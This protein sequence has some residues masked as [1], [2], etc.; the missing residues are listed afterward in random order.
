MRVSLAGVVKA[1]GAHTVL[2][3]VDLALGLRSRL[4]LV[5]P[6]GAGK[7]TLLRLLAGVEEPDE[8]RVERTPADLTVGYLPQEHD[9]RPGETLLAFLARRTGVAAAEAELE[10]HTSAWDADAYAAALERFL[11]LGGGDLEHRAAAVCAELGLPVSLGQETATLSGGEAA[12]AGLAA[13]LLSRF[14]VLLLDEPTNDLDFD[15]LE[16]LERFLGRFDGGLAVVSHDRAFLDRTIERIAEIDPWTG[17]VREWAGTWSEYEAQRERARRRH[18]DAFERAQERRREIEG[19]LHERRA[20]ARAGGAMADRRGTHALMTKV[21]QAERALERVEAVDKPYEPWELRLSLAARQRTGDSV[22]SL[23]GAVGVRGDFRLGPVDVDLV[24]G[25]RLAVTGRNGSGKS[26]LLALLL[27][28]LPLAAGRRVVGRAT[29]LGALDQRRL[30]Y[31]GAD[32]LLDAFVERS[33]VTSLEARTLLAKFNLTADHVARACGTLSPGER[34]RAH[35]AELMA[36]GVNCLVLDEPT[37]HLDLEAIEELESALAAY[38]GTTV[39][40]SHDR[41]FLERVA[42]TRVLQL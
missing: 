42:P 38:G 18:Y 24:P 15:G 3:R 33:G 9:A 4:G 13:I 6:N 16:R 31:D 7:S 28:E 39:V 5:G 11:A 26:T 14:D 17:R 8:G 19:L 40:V 23:E 21:R 30:A 25:E 1:Y 34:T 2:D 27:G 37:N 35:L 20:Q 32:S 29:V 36:R 10:R 12:R 22:V 41:R